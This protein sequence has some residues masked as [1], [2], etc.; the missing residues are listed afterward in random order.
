MVF[1]KKRSLGGAI[2]AIA[3]AGGIAG[4]ILV[5]KQAAEEFDNK[6]IKA[7]VEDYEAGFSDDNHDDIIIQEI[8]V[9]DTVDETEFI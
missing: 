9:D 3:A 6:H 5:Y 2:L 8:P 4:G 7:V 1:S